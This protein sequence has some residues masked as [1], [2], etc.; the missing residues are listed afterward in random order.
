MSE[1]KETVGKIARDLM[2][3]EPETRSPIDIQREV[4]KEFE[5]N[6]IEAAER[7]KKEVVGDFYLVVITKKE[8]LLEN[9]LRNYF[10]FRRSCPTPEWDQTVYKYH[11]SADHI[12]FL[13][14]VPSRDTCAIMLQNKAYVPAEERELLNF[15]VQ[16]ED[17]TLFRLAKKLN[18]EMADSPLLEK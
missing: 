11:R 5:S 13:W 2:M 10:Y 14:T 16:Y 9:V 18:G 12:E 6:L 17:G 1:N 8:R 4:H 3:K 15:V 7:G